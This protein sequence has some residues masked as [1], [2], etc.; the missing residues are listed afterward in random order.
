M[1]CRWNCSCSWVLVHRLVVEGDQRRRSILFFFFFSSFGF[2]WHIWNSFLC[3]WGWGG[4]QKNLFH[5]DCNLICS[6]FE[7]YYCILKDVIQAIKETAF[8]TSEYP[9]I[10]S[11]ENHCRYTVTFFIYFFSTMDEKD[12]KAQKC[13][14]LNVLEKCVG[15]CRYAGCHLERNVL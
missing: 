2:T 15:V 10:L 4:G 11:F 7:S 8:V 3:F 6:N 14:Y 9:V 12:D 1:G 5:Y 13:Y